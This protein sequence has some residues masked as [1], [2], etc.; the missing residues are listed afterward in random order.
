MDETII[1]LRDD[2]LVE[3]LLERA[4]I[5][6]RSLD[7]EVAD[8]LSS[9]VGVK[10]QG[11]DRLASAQRISAMTPKGVEQTDSTILVR[12]HRDGHS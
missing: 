4:K 8:V 1:T 3:R 6:N 12:Q 2:G 11:F 5:H 9:V 10:R 7:E